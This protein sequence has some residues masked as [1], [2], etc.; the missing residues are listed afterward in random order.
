MTAPGTTAYCFH[1]RPDKFDICTVMAL[2]N[3][4]SNAFNSRTP[5]EAEGRCTKG[6]LQLGLH[7]QETHAE[8]ITHQ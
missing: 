1:Q 7:L 5:T 8:F 3:I 2:L 6:A 4:L